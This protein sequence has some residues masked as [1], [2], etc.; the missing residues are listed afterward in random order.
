MPVKIAPLATPRLDGGICGKMVGAVR[1]I[2]VPPAIPESTLHTK[3]QT[4]DDGWLQA[5]K[6]TVARTIIDRRIALTGNCLTA[7]LATTAPAR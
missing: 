6:A 1:T 2:S 7:K 5:K 3:N 4:N